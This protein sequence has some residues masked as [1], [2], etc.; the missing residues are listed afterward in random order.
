VTGD[1]APVE[2]KKVRVTSFANFYKNFWTKLI[3]L[4]W[5]PSWKVLRPELSKITFK[6]SQKLMGK[7]LAIRKRKG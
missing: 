7:L 4:M 2:G 1:Y 3:N 5:K 6:L